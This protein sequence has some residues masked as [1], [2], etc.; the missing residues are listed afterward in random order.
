MRILATLVLSVALLSG[1]MACSEPPET[2]FNNAQFEEL[3]NNH[4]HARELYN[5]I[6]KKH[7]DSEFALKATERLEQLEAPSE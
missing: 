3:Q 5:E 7:P 4:E 2:L 1:V 6:I